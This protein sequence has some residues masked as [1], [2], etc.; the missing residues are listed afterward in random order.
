MG[1]N[2]TT[3]AKATKERVSMTETSRD[4]I[5]LTFG[6][7]HIGEYKG[8]IALFNN[9]RFMGTL[10]GESYWHNGHDEIGKVLAAVAGDLLAM[11]NQVMDD[12]EFFVCG[13]CKKIVHADH[14][15]DCYVPS[16]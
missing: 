3:V 15:D 13:K 7:W 5:G 12:E 9:G 10:G 6:P 16:I 8:G 2:L 4:L 1:E 11:A 14:C